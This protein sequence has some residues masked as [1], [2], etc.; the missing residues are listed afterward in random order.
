MTLKSRLPTVTRDQVLSTSPE[1][2]TLPP[3]QHLH[4]NSVKQEPKLEPGQSVTRMALVPGTQ[5]GPQPLPRGPREG[6]AWALGAAMSPG[7][8]SG[9]LASAWTRLPGSSA[10]M[11]ASGRWASSSL[12]V[13]VAGEGVLGP[14]G[15]FLGWKS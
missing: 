9:S 13:R 15:V 2:S 4:W 12:Q 3:D 6:A 5:P 11:R 1:V 10:Q 8:R 14:G 7:C